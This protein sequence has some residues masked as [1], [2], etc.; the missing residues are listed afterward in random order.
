MFK[1]RQI[2]LYYIIVNSTY[3]LFIVEYLYTFLKLIFLITYV[4]HV[5]I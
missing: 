4:L 5:E 2:I 1:K 3:L